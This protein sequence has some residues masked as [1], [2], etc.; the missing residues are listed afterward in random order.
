[1]SKI[2][3]QSNSLYNIKFVR[4][5]SSET[6]ANYNG[7]AELVLGNTN[8]FA[9][10]VLHKDTNAKGQKLGVDS[11]GGEIINIGVFPDGSETTF[12]DTVSSITVNKG[13]WQF[14]TDSGASGDTGF[15]TPGRTY[16]LGANNDAIT[17]IRRIK[18]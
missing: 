9:D 11:P 6:A 15:L 8:T 13:A 2:D 16:N 10:I 12:N 18:E 1:M 3:T 14:F 4:D 7:G 5:I 17:S